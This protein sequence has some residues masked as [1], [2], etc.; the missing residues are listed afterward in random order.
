MAETMILK[1]GANGFELAVP[2]KPNWILLRQGGYSPV[3]SL[4]NAVAACGGYVYQEVLENS[5]IV[6]TIQEVHVSYERNLEKKAH[7]IK[8]ITIHFLTVGITKEQQEKAQRCLRLVSPN[9]PVIQSLDPAIE[10]IKTVA[11]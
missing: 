6:G 9:C 4:V 1:K 8:T 2:D 11:F 7:P 10:V 5:K 3:Q